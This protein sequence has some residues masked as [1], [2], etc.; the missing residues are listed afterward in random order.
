MFGKGKSKDKN[1]DG[2]MKSSKDKNELTKLKTWFKKVANDEIK[3]D[4][5]TQD[6]PDYVIKAMEKMVCSNCSSHTPLLKDTNELMRFMM[7]MD[8][9]KDMINDVNEQAEVVETVAAS[10]QEMSATI[11]DVSHFVSDSTKAASDT[12]DA[13]RD[14]MKQVMDAFHFIQESFDQVMETNKQIEGVRDKTTKID[15]MVELIKSVADQTNLLA[16]NASIEAARAGEAGRGFSVVAEEIKKLAESTKESVDF[17]Q[18]SIDEL[19]GQIGQ[20]VK[21]MEGS[22]TIF[23]KGR[24]R[25]E[26]ATKAIDGAVKGVEGIQENMGQIS[27]SIDQQTAA[28]E[29]VAG[30]LTL[31][32]D[33]TKKL[34]G[35]CVRTGQA[36][37]DISVGIDNLRRDMVHNSDYINDADSID[38]CITDHLNW[39]WRIYNMILG[40]DKIDPA[41]MGD[42]TKCRLG[43]WITMRGQSK[44]EFKAVVERIHGP[45]EKLHDLAMAA[46]KAYKQDDHEAADHYLHQMDEVSRDVVKILN[47]LKRLA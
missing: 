31:I 46:V 27:T 23:E 21:S 24:S 33:R 36:M 12:V 15:E 22:Q 19:R 47:E 42:H 37:F 34:Y 41:S 18:T 20:A 39:R 1:K 10:S 8:F 30:N 45:H 35:E 17:I 3:W 6:I 40:Y 26:D 5:N 7:G 9:V 4:E 2:S 29:E 14:S 25:V 38:L 44:P 28:S 43:R 16:L 32:N 11:E 13:T